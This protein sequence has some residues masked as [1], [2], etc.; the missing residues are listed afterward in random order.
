M[1]ALAGE[2]SPLS[3]YSGDRIIF[4]D[5]FSVI[6]SLLRTNSLPSN[7]AKFDVHDLSREARFYGLD[8]VLRSIGIDPSVDQIDVVIDVHWYD[9]AADCWSINQG[10]I[11][12]KK[13]MIG[14]V[15]HV[16]ENSSKFID[17][18]I[19]DVEGEKYL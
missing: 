14:S 6:L 9:L 13:I 16:D 7:A 17:T 10:V 2:R 8:Q 15:P 4:I 5:L 19:Y 1:L 12:F 11:M 3:S 18:K